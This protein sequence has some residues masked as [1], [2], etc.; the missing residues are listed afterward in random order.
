MW[1]GRQKEVVEKINWN[2][3]TFFHGGTELPNVMFMY[4]QY[5]GWMARMDGRRIE[6]ARESIQE[7]RERGGGGRGGSRRRINNNNNIYKP[8][9]HFTPIT[10]NI[11]NTINQHHF[12]QKTFQ[13][14]P[15][16]PNQTPPKMQF[17]ALLATAALAAAAPSV[18]ETRGGEKVCA[19][20]A[21]YCCQ[22]D[23][24]GV[25]AVSCSD[26]KYLFY[27]T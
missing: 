4:M 27:L 23:V 22:L 25:A 8:T 14:N 17:F 18:L 21:P 24:L 15:T 16:T 3:E 2:V 10:I 12:F 20:G 26:G 19:S 11:I 1:L 5:A 7:G 6:R 9:R 13:S